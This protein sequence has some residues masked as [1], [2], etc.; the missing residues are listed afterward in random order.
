LIKR[1]LRQK[2]KRLVQRVIGI[3]ISHPWPLGWGAVF[4]LVWPKRKLVPRNFLL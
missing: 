3:W 1:T 4:S 2:N